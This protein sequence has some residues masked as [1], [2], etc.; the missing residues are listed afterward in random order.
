MSTEV[1]STHRL[2]GGEVNK[3]DNFGTKQ[4]WRCIIHGYNI[5]KE[6]ES[7]G[8]RTQKT[9]HRGRQRR[10]CRRGCRSREEGKGGFVGEV[11]DRWHSPMVQT[12]CGS[13]FRIERYIYIFCVLPHLEST[14]LGRVE[15]QEAFEEVLTVCGHVERD[16]VLPSEHT[17][18]Q[19]LQGRGT[20]NRKSTKH[21]TMRWVIFWM[22]NAQGNHCQSV[23]NIR[24]SRRPQHC[25]TLRFCPSKG[26]EPLT[27]VYR[28]TPRLQTSTSGPSY[29]FPWKSSG[30]AYGGEPQNV[31]SLLPI[32]NSLLKPKSAILM[33]MSASSSRFSA[34]GRT[35]EGQRLRCCDAIIPH[36]FIKE[37]K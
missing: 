24:S 18:P 31:S 22:L 1:P 30:A 7:V 23:S 32:V 27:S 3:K 28:M 5:R 33:F 8:R 25:P 14:P 10:W 9:G 19:L 29:F 16:A 6:E 21:F 17:L 4:E 11:E 26:S 12:C 36:T 37:L 20:T 2:K 34:W 15:H 35:H 13:V